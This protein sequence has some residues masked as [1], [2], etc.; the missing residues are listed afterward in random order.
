MLAAIG[1]VESQHADN[2]NLDPSGTTLTPILGPRLDGTNG[3]AAIR[4][5]DGGAL[6]GD[7][8]WD[9]AVGPMQFIP[10]AWRRYGVT[11]DGAGPPNPNNEV[12][13]PTIGVWVRTTR[14][15]Q[16]I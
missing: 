8:T 16:S 13:S 7:K 2:G 14:A 12:I 11:I 4:D 10:S 1:Q 5:T 9:R 3:F 6:D 15:K